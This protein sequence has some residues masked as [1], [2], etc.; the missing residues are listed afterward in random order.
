MGVTLYEPG[1]SCGWVILYLHGNSSSRLECTSIMEYL[2]DR[3]GLASFDFL[4]CGN[5][6]EE[7]MVTLGIREA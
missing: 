4:G 3:V 5:N 6:H 7:D 2:P 1:E